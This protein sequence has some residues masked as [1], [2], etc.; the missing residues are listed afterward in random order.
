MFCD[1]R[2]SGKT[3]VVII[4]KT[5]QSNVSVD[6]VQYVDNVYNNHLYDVAADSGWVWIGDPWHPYTNP[7]F[8][9]RRIYYGPRSEA[10]KF[11]LVN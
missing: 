2:I 3:S 7:D 6:G 9:M 5:A 8:Q 11:G 4:F 1:P 10:I